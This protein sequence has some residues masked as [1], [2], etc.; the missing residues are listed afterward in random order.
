[1]ELY[2]W[3]EREE[4]KVEGYLGNFYV[5]LR[6]KANTK[7]CYDLTKQESRYNIICYI[8]LCTFLFA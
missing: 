3:R 2:L 1:M 6:P 4:Y 7:Q 5:I 8:T